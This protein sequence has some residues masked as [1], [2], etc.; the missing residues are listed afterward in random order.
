VIG[1]AQKPWLTLFSTSNLEALA[2]A[3]AAQPETDP[4]T[5]DATLD[6]KPRPLTDPEHSELSERL[7][8]LNRAQP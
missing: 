3:L 6:R 8:A 2:E 7:A 5:I 1:D 4:S